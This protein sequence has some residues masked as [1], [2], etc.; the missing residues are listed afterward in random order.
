MAMGARVEGEK[1]FVDHFIEHSID[2]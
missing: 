1:G 2:S